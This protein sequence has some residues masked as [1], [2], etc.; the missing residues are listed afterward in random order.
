MRVLL[1]LTLLCVC[2][3]SIAEERD[4]ETYLDG[5]V[6]AQFK[7]YKLAGM[8]FVMVQGDQITLAK[9]YGAADL[10]SGEPVDPGG[11]LLLQSR[12]G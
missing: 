2:T 12:S 7:D 4:F 6:A 9:G 1:S 8:T 11:D 10:Q 3:F 5:L